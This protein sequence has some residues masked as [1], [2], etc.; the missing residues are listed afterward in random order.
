MS[1]ESSP[2]TLPLPLCSA[3]LPI[4]TGQLP[5]ESARRWMNNI[6]QVMQRVKD[7]A[8]PAMAFVMAVTKSPYTWG[9]A[10]TLYGCLTFYW[11]CQKHIVAKEIREDILA[12]YDQL[13]VLIREVLLAFWSIIE[14]GKDISNY[15]VTSYY[16][17]LVD[18]CQNISDAERS[19]YP[20]YPLAAGA[21]ST[22]V[23]MGIFLTAAAPAAVFLP[24]MVSGIAGVA[25]S[26]QIIRYQRQTHEEK[27]K[28]LARC[29]NCQKLCVTMIPIMQTAAV[30][31]NWEGII[32]VTSLT[33]N[34]RECMKNFALAA[35]TVATEPKQN[36]E[37]RMRN[38]FVRHVSNF[39]RLNALR[40]CLV[41]F[42][43]FDRG[44]ES[45]L[46][47]LLCEASN[48]HEKEC[49][50]KLKGTTLQDFTILG[51]LGR[52]PTHVGV[53]E[54]AQSIVFAATLTEWPDLG[55]FA[56]KVGISSHNRSDALMEQFQRDLLVRADMDRRRLPHHPNILAV[57]HVFTDAAQQ[58]RGVSPS[59]TALFDTYGDG[60][61]LTKNLFVVTKSWPSSLKR[62]IAHDPFNDGHEQ[63]CLSRTKQMLRAVHHLSTHRMVHRD[64]KPDNVLALGAG[65][66]GSVCVMDFGEA[67]DCKAAYLEGFSMPFPPGRGIRNGGAQAYLPPEIKKKA[68]K[69]VIL[70]YSKSDLWSVGLILYEMLAGPSV[71]AYEGMTAHPGKW[72][73]GGAPTWHPLDPRYTTKT[74]QLCKSLLSIDLGNRLTVEQALKHVDDAINHI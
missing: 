37:V 73:A 61:C 26:V 8:N 13:F 34:Q 25:R 23:G 12:F 41:T 53:Y 4:S 32:G 47:K 3:L 62:H 74:R 48:N 56:L 60:M 36:Y 66:T 70:N 68:G 55:Q 52:D 1:K 71:D 18:L 40:R 57:L 30:T 58:L 21:C 9:I 69:D 54:G 59:T 44:L 20:E 17:R 42:P 45:P 2:Q 46:F 29:R 35:S 65:N 49:V 24:F 33:A 31:T 19:V 15:N 50:E 10:C 64:L 72:W 51:R 67:L 28:L 39:A 7:A 16:K 27:E 6:L 14:G 5:S 63:L 38:I 43:E 22:F 11:T